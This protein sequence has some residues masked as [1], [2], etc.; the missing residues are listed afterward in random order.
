[1][2]NVKVAQVSLNLVG[3]GCDIM[4]KTSIPNKLNHKPM[5]GCVKKIKKKKN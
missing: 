4:R 1:M 2:H 3:Y 5:Q